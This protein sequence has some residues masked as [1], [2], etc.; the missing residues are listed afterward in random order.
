MPTPIKDKVSRRPLFQTIKEEEL[1]N[2]VFVS[3]EGRLNQ[4]RSNDI[5]SG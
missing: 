4:V 2:V 5:K 1:K 3:D